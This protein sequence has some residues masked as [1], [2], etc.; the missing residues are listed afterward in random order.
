MTK[1]LLLL[2]GDGIGIEIM[3]EVEK[4]ISQLNKSGKTDFSIETGLVGGTAYDA[5][6]EAISD[7]DMA[8]AMDADAVIFGAVGGEKWSDVPYEKRPE[9]GLLRLRKDLQLFANLRPAICYP[10]CGCFCAEKTSG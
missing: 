9:A 2:P 4:L 7:A 6:G 5:H 8:K 10:A 1:K 3:A